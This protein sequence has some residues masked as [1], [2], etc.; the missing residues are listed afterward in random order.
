M[1]RS[2]FELTN[3]CNNDTEEFWKI[4]GRLGVGFERKQNIPME[5]KKDD[6]CISNNINDIKLKRKTHFL[7][8]A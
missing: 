8:S 5:I 6:G 7:R 1:E 2:Q 3:S 4:I